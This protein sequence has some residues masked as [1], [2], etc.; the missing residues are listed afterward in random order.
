MQFL[1]LSAFF[2]ISRM[3]GSIELKFELEDSRK[4][5]FYEDIKTPGDD[6]DIVFYVMDGGRKDVTLEVA[7]PKRQIMVKKVKEQNGEVRVKAMTK[8][9]YSIC[10]S[11]EF[12]S[13]SH[14]LVYIEIT[15]N[16]RTRE[17]EQNQKEWKEKVDDAQKS[18]VVAMTALETSVNYIAKN[19]KHAG[20][21][22]R[23][24]RKW[25]WLSEFHIDMLLNSV[26]LGSG[27][28]IITIVVV[29]LLQTC[30]LRRMFSE[31]N[32][33]KKLKSFSASFPPPIFT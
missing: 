23:K 4:D 2:L 26:D 3:C 22:L 18:T 16:S 20:R 14:K 32:L 25:D 5:C 27:A 9:V 17:E 24:F 28:I 15:T 1:R 10:F 6:I 8:G 29:S 13:F 19:M 31:K 33:A 7:D 11:N 21:G 30:F 12:S